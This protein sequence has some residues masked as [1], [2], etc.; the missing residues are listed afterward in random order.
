MKRMQR[1]PTKS[2]S[3]SRRRA[4]QFT[5]PPNHPS[6]RSPLLYNRATAIQAQAV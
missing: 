1:R 5:N 4:Y 2:S 6:H 3:D